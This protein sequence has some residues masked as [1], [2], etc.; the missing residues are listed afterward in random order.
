M[1]V[2]MTGKAVCRKALVCP[3]IQ[4]CL[5]PEDVL[6]FDVDPVVAFVAFLLCVLPFKLETNRGMVERLGIEADKGKI[7]P[8][9]LLMA[10]H[11]LVTGKGTVKAGARAHP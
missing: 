10:F 4:H 3:R 5:I 2:E 7:P 9:M 1:C 11:A 6:G 8:V